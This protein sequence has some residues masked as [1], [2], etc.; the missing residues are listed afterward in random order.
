MQKRGILQIE[1]LPGL[2]S[3][4]KRPRAIEVQGKFGHLII[5]GLHRRIWIHTAP[6]HMSCWP[7]K[8]QI[9]LSCILQTNPQHPNEI[10]SKS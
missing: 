6:R 7:L 1:N 4:F 9:E 3:T 5:H 10:N 2:H 8:L